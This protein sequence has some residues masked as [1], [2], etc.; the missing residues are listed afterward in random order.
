MRSFRQ[1]INRLSER[2]FQAGAGK[3]V[4]LVPT[5]DGLRSLDGEHLFSDE[6]EAQD[7]Y[8]PAIAIVKIHPSIARTYRKPTQGRDK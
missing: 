2:A 3:A 5:R 7:Y 4:A 8:G 6:R 1:R